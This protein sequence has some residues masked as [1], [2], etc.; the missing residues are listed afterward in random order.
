MPSKTKDN[1]SRDKF[2]ILSTSSTGLPKWRQS[3]IDINREQTFAEKLPPLLISDHWLAEGSA[4]MTN[5]GRTVSIELS[6]RRMPSIRGGPL[7][8]DEFRFMNVQFRWGP[9]DLRGAE[10][11]INNI[12]NSMEA[13]VMHWNTRYGSIEKCYD[14]PDGI[15]ILS[16]LMQVVG[17]RGAPGNPALFAITDHLWK[18]KKP[19]SST[20]VP[21]D[22]LS[23]MLEACLAPGYYT[24]SG[25][26]TAYPF[27]ECVTW[28]ILPTLIK[29]SSQQAEAFRCIYNGKLENIVRNYRSQ[30]NLHRRRVLHATG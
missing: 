11:S 26:L 14:K 10:H 7:G 23:W 25:S 15:A 30:Q 18:I 27:N 13:Q 1:R 16:Y 22:C 3:P 29:I 24:Y 12:W 19:G 8:G 20:A 28:I 21:P 6:N 2:S 5:T 9:H 4:V 17:C